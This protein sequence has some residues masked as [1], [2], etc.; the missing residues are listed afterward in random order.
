MRNI[1]FYI[2]IKLNINQVLAQAEPP[3]QVSLTRMLSETTGQKTFPQPTRT[4][5]QSN[6]G[7]CNEMWITATCSPAP[8]VHCL[9]HKRG[10]HRRLSE[11]HSFMCSREFALHI[12]F[13]LLLKRLF[14]QLVDEFLSIHLEERDR[15]L[16][17]RGG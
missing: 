12:S 3:H 11:P 10:S 4:I 17:Q 7:C 16:K 13:L 8:S 9:F 2:R 5:P 15:V 6:V 14:F 1:S